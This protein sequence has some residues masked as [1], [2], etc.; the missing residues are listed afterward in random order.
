VT[1]NSIT[2]ATNWIPRNFELG[3]VPA[4]LTSASIRLLCTRLAAPTGT[5]EFLR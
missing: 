3:F 1:P 2:I 4:T 5:D